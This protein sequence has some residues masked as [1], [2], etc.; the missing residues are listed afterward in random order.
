MERDKHKILGGNTKEENPTSS[1]RQLWLVI[2][3]RVFQR[4]ASYGMKRSIIGEDTEERRLLDRER[5]GA[6][7]RCSFFRELKA[8]QGAP[9]RVEEADHRLSQWQLEQSAAH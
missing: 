1:P 9:S 8:A 2:T 4:E 5:P 7:G 3:E 6:R